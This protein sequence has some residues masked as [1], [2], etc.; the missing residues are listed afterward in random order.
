MTENQK[1]QLKAEQDWKASP[2]YKT[3]VERVA[4]R[5]KK[6]AKVLKSKAKN[7]EIEHEEHD[8]HVISAFCLKCKNCGVIKDILFSNPKYRNVRG[9]DR[10]YEPTCIEKV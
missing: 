7:T 10:D 1:R 9:K 4:D 3:D 2:E 5:Q 8:Y 6:I